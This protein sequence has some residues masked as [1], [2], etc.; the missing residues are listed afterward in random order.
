MARRSLIFGVLARLLDRDQGADADGQLE[1]IDRHL[2]PDL[3]AVVAPGDALRHGPVPVVHVLVQYILT[4]RQHPEGKEELDRRPDQVVSVVA[5]ERL[6]GRVDP[7][8]P[9]VRVDRHDGDGEGLDHGIEQ[10]VPD[11]HPTAGGTGRSHGR[12]MG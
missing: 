7:R 11:R 8:D 6:G 12:S 9:A 10:I 5:E 2:D 3:A 4:A 1:G